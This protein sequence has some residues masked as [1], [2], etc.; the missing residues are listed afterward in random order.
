MPTI[1]VSPHQ[2]GRVGHMR[3]GCSLTSRAHVRARL[4]Q[5]YG[6]RRGHD[7]RPFLVALLEHADG[8]PAGLRGGKDPGGGVV[9]SPDAVKYVYSGSKTLGEPLQG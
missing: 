6:G 5:V 2:V 4:A 3:R 1:E 9:T 7:R 8:A